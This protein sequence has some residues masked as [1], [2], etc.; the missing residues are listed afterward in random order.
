LESNYSKLEFFSN[1]LELPYTLNSYLLKNS[2]LDDFIPIPDFSYS[3]LARKLY[4]K[5]KRTMNMRKWGLNA[6]IKKG[7]MKY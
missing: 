5:T 1:K 3:K 4:S 2:Q 7:F 6:Y